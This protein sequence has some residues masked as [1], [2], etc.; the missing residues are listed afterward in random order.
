MKTFELSA[1]LQ[2]QAKMFAKHQETLME[3]EH[4]KF[5]KQQ[6]QQQQLIG[7]PKLNEVPFEGLA[8]DGSRF[9]FMGNCKANI[10]FGTKKEVMDCF[11]MEG[12]HNIVGLPWLRKF[13]YLQR[14][15]ITGT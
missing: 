12:V 1:I 7:C 4:Q 11:V 10:E 3:V 2:N 14:I 9:K 15:G 8:V 13:N 5:A 6:V